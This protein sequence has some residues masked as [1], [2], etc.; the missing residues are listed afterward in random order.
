[1]KTSILFIMLLILLNVIV[2]T[3]AIM[4]LYTTYA[5]KVPDLNYS[6]IA[7]NNYEIKK[8]SSM[9]RSATI[10]EMCTYF[11]VPFYIL[12]SLCAFNAILVIIASSRIITLTKKLYL[13]NELNKI[14]ET[15]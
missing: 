8:V 15:L 2:I 3:F 9:A 12:I 13:K 11:K 14:Y 10:N 6:D 7:K 1:M 4:P 5:E